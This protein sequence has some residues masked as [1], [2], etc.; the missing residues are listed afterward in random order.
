[1]LSIT[2]RKWGYYITL[3]S[4]ARFKVKILRFYKDASCSKQYHH[5]RNELWLVLKGL[6]KLNTK[7]LQ[8]G[9]WHAIHRRRTHQFTALKPSWILEIQYG[10]KC[11]EDDIVRL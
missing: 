11:S 6:G 9:D 2:K 5:Y 8:A 1:M 10:D 4:A 7:T 3:I